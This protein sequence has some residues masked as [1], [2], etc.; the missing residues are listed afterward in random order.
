MIV[1]LAHVLKNPT[2]ISQSLFSKKHYLENKN[3]PY[4]HSNTV[5]QNKLSSI[6]LYKII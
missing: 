5:F 1:Y 3:L 6:L 4:I 2:T